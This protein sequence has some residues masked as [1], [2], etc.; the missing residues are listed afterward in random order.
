MS[1][2]NAIRDALRS[3]AACVTGSARQDVNQESDE[4]N[5]PAT[6]ASDWPGALMR[7]DPTADGPNDLTYAMSM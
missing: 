7:Y 5:Q 3:V 4:N 1:F 6:T 2:P